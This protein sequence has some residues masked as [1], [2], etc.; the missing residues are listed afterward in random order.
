MLILIG[1]FL[2]QY[3]KS[4]K[5][6]P[7]GQVIRSIGFLFL[8]IG[9]IRAASGAFD[10]HGDLARVLEIANRH[11]LGMALFATVLTIVLQSSTASVGL[12]IG[13]VGSNTIQLSSSALVAAIVGANVGV[14]FTTLGLAWGRPESQRMAI[15][16]LLA[17]GL[18]GAI[19]LAA[20]PWVAKF[21]EYMPGSVAQHVANSHT[22]FNIA[23]AL[24]TL[25][26]VGL[27]TRISEG[28]IPLPPQAPA[29]SFGPRYI[30]NGPIEGSSL[31]LGQSMREI[32][33]VSDIVR[34]MYDDWWR[35][36]VSS[37]EQLARQ[38]ADRDDQVDLLEKEI[39]QFLASVGTGS[40]DSEQA[41]EQMRQQRYL[42]E[43][44]TS[45][46]IIEKNLCVLVTRKV[47]SGV[48]LSADKWKELE[49]FSH[50]VTENMLLADTAFHTHDSLAAQKL[51]RHKD[52]IS[53]CADELRD[54]HFKRLNQG[55]AESHEATAVYF[56]MIN[57]LRRINS[58]VAHVA[59][60]IL[61]DER[62]ASPFHQ[63]MEKAGNPIKGE[64]SP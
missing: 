31:A 2:H 33:H 64:A 6:Q 14:A 25:P 10:S 57:C 7:T 9:I 50:M 13:L 53:R 24:L 59:Y 15:G 47:H 21:L 42:S 45:A 48:T 27:L 1:V 63:L 30:G 22:G 54:E 40:I 62:P 8:A 34:A 5:L 51:L 28:L 23:V 49:V 3:T 58:H 41:A 37:N 26:L 16:F 39:Q 36:F 35:A 32:L 17:K 43:L 12:L 11:S 29:Q 56:E 44:E 52:A 20:L 18:V 46:D 61:R 19:V 55:L 4:A 60:A 38:V